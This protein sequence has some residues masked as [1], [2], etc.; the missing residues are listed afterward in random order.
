MHEH[1]F[2]RNLELEVNLP[3][4]EWDAADAIETAAKGLADLSELGIRTVVDMTVPGLGR[5]VAL[6]GQFAERVPV[7]R[8]AATGWYTQNALPP[9]FRFHVPVQEIDS[10]DGRQGSLVRSGLTRSHS[11]SRRSPTAASQTRQRALFP[12]VTT[13]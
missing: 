13:F 9:Y 8:I 7:N 1:I 12:L 2:V 10:V 4:G 6:V 5:D 3:D 11:T